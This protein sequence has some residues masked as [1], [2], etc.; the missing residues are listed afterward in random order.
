MSLNA[1]ARRRARAVR[2]L[3]ALAVALLVV[4]LFAGRDHSSS[5]RETDPAPTAPSRIQGPAVRPT[6]VRNPDGTHVPCPVG[7]EPAVSLEAVRFTPALSGG[8]RLL[9]GAYRVL[10]RGSVVNETNMPIVVRRL[11]VTIGGRRWDAVVRRPQ[12]V[13]AQDKRPLMIR[14]TFVSTATAH[15]RLATRM[16]WGW[17]DARLKPCRSKGLV[18]DD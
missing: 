16:S 5:A 6:T 10:A 17:Q 3:L 8:T 2:V 14:G 12:R 18:E 4:G 7:A 15:A 9:R 1:P 13:A 11:V